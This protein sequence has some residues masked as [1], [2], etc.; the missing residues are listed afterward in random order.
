MRCILA[1]AAV[2]GYLRHEDGHKFLKET[3]DV[4]NFA[5]DLLKA[6]RATL[7]TLTRATT[8]EDPI[9]GESLRLSVA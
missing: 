4:P 5:A 6:V 1:A 9:T 3:Q 7:K 2:E 8:F